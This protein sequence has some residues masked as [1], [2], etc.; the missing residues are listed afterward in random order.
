[1]TN[2]CSKHDYSVTEAFMAID[3][4]SGGDLGEI[5]GLLQHPAGEGLFAMVSHGLRPA[6]AGA[7]KVLSEIKRLAG[8]PVLNIF[9]FDIEVIVHYKYSSTRIWK[10]V[11]IGVLAG[12]ES[13]E[14]S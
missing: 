7:C 10:N 14:S 3:Y 5:Q 12:S 13:R 8:E 9:L 4:K 6:D 11:L 2:R 1:M